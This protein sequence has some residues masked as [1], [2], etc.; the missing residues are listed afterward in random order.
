MNYGGSSGYG[1]NYISRLDGQW[2][3]TDVSD[4][5]AAARA[6]STGPNALIDPTRTIIRGE[7]AGGLTTLAAL[8]CAPDPDHKFFAAGV[9]LY[10]ISNIEILANGETHKF[11]SRYGVSL[12]V[13]LVK[14]RY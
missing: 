9:S 5:V 13:D 7:S 12:L 3:V 1:R 4:C 6:L 11:E 2:G 8:A 10:G 14:R